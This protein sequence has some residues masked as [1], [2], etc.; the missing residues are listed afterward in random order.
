M[1]TIKSIIYGVVILG[2]ALAISGCVTAEAER[3]HEPHV[4]STTTHETSLR[5]RPASAT[6]ETQSV[7]TY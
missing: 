5:T 3:E 7:R 2:G 4:S 6:V 1:H